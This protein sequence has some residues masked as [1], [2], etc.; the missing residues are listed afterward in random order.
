MAL[1]IIGIVTSLI[2]L[3]TLAYRGVPVILAAPVASAVAVVF[4][5]APILASYTEIFI[6]ET[7]P[8][9]FC[10]MPREDVPLLDLPAEEGDG[11]GED[12][13]VGDDFLF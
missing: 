13:Q 12:P 4:S 7:V 6:P 10:R 1:G 5:G 2:L 8:Q 11:E 3:I 9:H